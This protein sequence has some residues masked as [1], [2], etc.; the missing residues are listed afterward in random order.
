M[1]TK[2]FWKDTAERAIKT[3]LQNILAILLISGTTLLNADW[4]AGLAVAAT[5]AVVSL[6]TSVVSGAATKTEGE[7]VTASVLSDVVYKAPV[8]EV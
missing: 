8:Q 1:W 2:D 3:F 4:Q 6:L 5:A 7:P